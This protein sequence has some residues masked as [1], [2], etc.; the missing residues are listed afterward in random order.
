V[1]DFVAGEMR[2]VVYRVRM[3]HEAR[4]PVLA[5]GLMDARSELSVE[6]LAANLDRDGNVWR[7][8]Q[9]RA[10]P[11]DLG[12]LGAAF[13]RKRSPTTLERRIV[14][15]GRDSMVVWYSYPPTH[16]DGSRSL[17]GLALR[18]LGPEAIVTDRTVGSELEVRVLAPA[19]RALA[20]YVREL[21]KEATR[22]H[23]FR[24]LH[25]GPPRRPVEPDLTA[26]EDATLRAAR[27]AGFFE[28]P[29]RGS[30][31]GLAGKLGCSASTVSSRLRRAMA[32]LGDA[33]GAR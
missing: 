9:L 8:V 21:E 2:E 7:L 1:A 3:K 15:R 16:E 10:S 32:K 24:L 11:A 19:G 18:T 17:T 5:F 31:R 13:R 27:E 12:R 22:R 4:P 25:V 30:V 23:E 28:V 33:Y 14:S 20:G 26:A 29:R 6:T